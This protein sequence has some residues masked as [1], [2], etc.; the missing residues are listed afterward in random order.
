[1]SKTFSQLFFVRKTKRDEALGNVFLRMTVNGIRS[2]VSL[3]R[4]IKLVQWLSA[5][6]MAIGNTRDIKELNQYLETVRVRVFEI[7]RTL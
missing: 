2:E 4:E 5:R 3:H 7:H 1:M 6:G